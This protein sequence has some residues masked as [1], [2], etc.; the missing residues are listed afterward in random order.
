MESLTTGVDQ[1]QYLVGGTHRGTVIGQGVQLVPGKLGQAL[2]TGERNGYLDLGNTRDT[3]FG[4]LERCPQGVSL[5]LWLKM[6]IPDEYEAYYVNNGGQTS[7]SYGISI[8]GKLVPPDSFLQIDLKTKTHWYRFTYKESVARA[9]HHLAF[10]WTASTH[11]IAYLDGKYVGTS[12]KSYKAI[13]TTNYNTFF[14]GKPNNNEKYYGEAYLDELLFWDSAKPAEFFQ[15][16]FQF[17]SAKN[18]LHF[19]PNMLFRELRDS[20]LVDVSPIESCHPRPWTASEPHPC[21]LHCM[22]TLWCGAVVYDQRKCYYY[23][24]HEDYEIIVRPTPG[25]LLFVKV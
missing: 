7:S 21:R 16:L 22:W 20:N 18:K 11:V 17:Y 4:E 6:E 24:V 10:S 2:Y 14:I 15:D 3:C 19:L 8:H 1:K 12:D 9:W 23:N 13:Q 5:A 25:V